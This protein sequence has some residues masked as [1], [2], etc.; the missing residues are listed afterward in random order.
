MGLLFVSPLV[1]FPD[2]NSTLVS[3][4]KVILRLTVSQS[5][6]V[7]GHH[8]GPVTNF[9]F[10]LKLS[11]DCCKIVNMGALSDERLGLSP[12]ELVTILP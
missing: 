8:L 12:A 2:W 5:A 4:V 10:L 1:F 7:S 11:L 3:K 9:Y 6:L